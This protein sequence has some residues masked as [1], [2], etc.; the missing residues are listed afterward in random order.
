MRAYTRAMAS[1]RDGS[2]PAAACVDAISC[3]SPTKR[4][5]LARRHRQPPFD[6]GDRL[7]RAEPQV[8]QNVLENAGA[9]G[10]EERLCEH[11]GRPLVD[12]GRAH[13]HR[14]GRAHLVADQDDVHAVEWKRRDV[15]GARP[16][17][18]EARRSPLA[19]EAAQRSTRR[20]TRTRL[21]SRGR[22]SAGRPGRDGVQVGHERARGRALGAVDDLCCNRLGG[23]GRDDG[24]DDLRLPDDGGQVRHELDSGPLGVRPRPR[25]P[26]FDRPDDAGA[27]PPKSVRD[28]AAHRARA[29]DADD[30]GW[31]RNRST[32]LSTTFRSARKA[33]P[34]RSSSSAV[35]RATS[36]R[37]AS[38]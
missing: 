5:A 22:R 15:A 34:T 37:F 32:I 20:R 2:S 12:R 38:S 30:H 3:I 27:A 19:T 6:A 8:V 4:S 24:E 16:R 13:F 36:A 7:R 29:D 10:G 25:A 26:A 33:M 23:S 17:E 11:R 9:G 21:R 31:R 28:S 14:R 18:V 1:K 35:T